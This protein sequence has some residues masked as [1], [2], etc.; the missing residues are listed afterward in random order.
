M[1]QNVNLGNKM[2]QILDDNTLIKKYQETM[3]HIR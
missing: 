3:D 2:M 1:I